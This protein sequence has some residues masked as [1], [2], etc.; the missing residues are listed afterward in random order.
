MSNEPL[1]PEFELPSEQR[2][3]VDD[4]VAAQGAYQRYWEAKDRERRME[5]R[6]RYQSLNVYERARLRDE[7]DDYGR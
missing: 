7:D 4:S 1:T 5:A 2:R 3:N 6:R